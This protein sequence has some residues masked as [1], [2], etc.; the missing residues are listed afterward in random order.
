ALETQARIARWAEGLYELPQ[1]DPHAPPTAASAASAALP[2]EK[3]RRRTRSSDLDRERD[4]DHTRSRARSRRSPP[5]PLPMQRERDVPPR[6]QTAPPQEIQMQHQHPGFGTVYPVPV[7]P[8]YPGPAPGYY[9][10]PPLQPLQP[11]PQPVP[12]PMSVRHGS[13]PPPS[14]GYP[15]LPPGYVY[16]APAPVPAPLYVQQPQ[17]MYAVHQQQQPPPP[18]RRELP[19]IKRLFRLSRESTR[20]HAI[21]ST[22]IALRVPSSSSPLYPILLSPPP[23]GCISIHYHDIREKMSE[24]TFSPEAY[25]RHFE[26]QHTRAAAEGSAC[27]ADPPVCRLCRPAP[28]EGAAH[29]VFRLRSR[30]ESQ[31]EALP[32]PAASDAARAPADRPAAADAPPVQPY[33]P[34]PGCPDDFDP[35]SDEKRC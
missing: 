11:L 35:V 2:R 4:R 24:Y 14:A 21:V 6:P 33:Y 17:P 5:P 10:T 20:P 29:A 3:D 30:P 13:Y 15:P 19:L 9:A 27:P 23:L 8:Y 7:Q 34:A 1:K 25:Q 28:P 18:T 12:V 16:A 32:A 22:P 31:Q 26:T